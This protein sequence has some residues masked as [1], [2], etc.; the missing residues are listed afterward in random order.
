MGH[1]AR[2]LDPPQETKVRRTAPTHRGGQWR[3]KRR[4]LVGPTGPPP[5]TRTPGVVVLPRRN[6]LEGPGMG[7]V[8]RRPERRRDG[9]NDQ[10]H[11]A[12]AAGQTHRT[13]EASYREK[14]L[15]SGK[16][17]IIIWFY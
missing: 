16:G 7:A 6:Q 5:I 11:T 1:R 10:G 13:G 4:R 12:E 2:P 14:S 17:A 8:R 3:R 9:A 15:Y